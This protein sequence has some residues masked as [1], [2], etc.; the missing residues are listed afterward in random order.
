LHPPQRH[1]T[2][3]FRNPSFPFSRHN[4]ITKT[5][6]Y[7]ASFL[8]N[9]NGRIK[10]VKT[11]KSSDDPYLVCNKVE[12]GRYLVGAAMPGLNHKNDIFNQ[13]LSP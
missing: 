13:S 2:A 9:F 6:Q 4:S 7:N 1:K 5:L 12:S 8:F 11:K 3:S 10:K